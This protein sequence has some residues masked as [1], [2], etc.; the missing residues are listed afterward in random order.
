MAGHLVACLLCGLFSDRYYAQATTMA[1]H[2][3]ACLLCGLS[4]D[5]F[6]RKPLVVYSC[7]AYGI[8]GSCCAFAPN[9]SL[10]CVLRFLLSASISNI[11]IN[12]SNL[13]WHMLQLVV[14]L[15][16]FIFFIVFWYA[17]QS[18]LKE[19]ENSTSKHFGIK[20]IIINPMMRKIVLC[21][22]SVFFAELF[23]NF[24][25][26]LDIRILGKNIFLNQILLGA[27][28][29]PCKL[30]TYFIMRNVSRRPSVVFSLLTTGSCIIITIF[31][32]EEMHVLRL[33]V[34]LL[35]KGSFATFN[36]VSV[37]YTQELSPTVL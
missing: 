12:S 27:V 3:V 4:S 33:I 21:Y 25:I 36:C 37:A 31:L 9:F 34:F 13:D 32:P 17:L 23:S 26:L 24:G 30:L 11:I 2:L 15:P 5:R 19:D 29:I 18:K 1:G 16:Y 20:D 10:Y 14:A 7:L 8:L 6:G 35:G 22:S 28:D